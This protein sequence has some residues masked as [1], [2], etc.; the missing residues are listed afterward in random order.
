MKLDAVPLI[1]RVMPSK[2]GEP[3]P[4]VRLRQA[5]K[6]LLR[7][8]RIRAEWEESAK[9]SMLAA[10]KNHTVNTGDSHGTWNALHRP[11]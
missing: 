8:F 3:A 9:C 2:P 10:A 1:L 4:E 7:G 11:S 6:L 5:L